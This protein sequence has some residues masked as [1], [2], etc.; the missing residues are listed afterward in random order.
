MELQWGEMSLQDF[1]ALAHAKPSTL[2]I[3]DE[4]IAYDSMYELLDPDLVRSVCHEVS[5][6]EAVKMEYWPRI[7]MSPVLVVGSGGGK[8]LR[9]LLDNGFDAYGIDISREV[10]KYY[11]DIP[12][13]FLVATSHNIPFAD[14]TFKTLVCADVLEHIKPELLDKT[15]DEFARVCTGVMMLWV[16]CDE[17]GGI[18]GMH[19]IIEKPEWWREKFERLGFI[20]SF[21]TGTPTAEQTKQHCG[22]LIEVKP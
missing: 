7:P 17:S 1:V 21:L 10:A 2:D 11:T 13:R 20:R 6:L 18:R 5:M 14:K 16:C 12:D 9:W 4:Q 15:L 22:A 8:G 19:H 3:A